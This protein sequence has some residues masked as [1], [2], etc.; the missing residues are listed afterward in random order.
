MPLPSEERLSLS[1]A[2]SKMMPCSS[3]II[4]WDACL[5]A[6]KLISTLRHE[7]MPCMLAHSR[8]VEVLASGRTVKSFV[9]VSFVAAPIAKRKLSTAI[10]V[11]TS[12]LVSA[13]VKSA[14]RTGRYVFRKLLTSQ[15]QRR[16]LLCHE[17]INYYSSAKFPEVYSNCQLFLAATRYEYAAQWV[18]SSHAT[19]LKYWHLEARKALEHGLLRPLSSNLRSEVTSE[20]IWRLLWPKRPP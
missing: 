15:V 8:I 20:V 5:I 18:I 7:S 14:S 16:V 9:V 2:R 12:F 19:I 6:S 4:T 11:E 1:P 13:M 3:A 10:N 17:P